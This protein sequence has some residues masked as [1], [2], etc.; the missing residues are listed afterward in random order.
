M[1]PTSTIQEALLTEVLVDLARLL[2]RAEALRVVNIESHDGLIGAHAQLVDQLTAFASQVGELTERAK[3]QTVKHILARTDEATR[4]AIDTQGKAMAKAANQLFDSRVD[5][6]IQQ[7][8]SVIARQ[9]ERLDHP[10][11][12]WLTHAATAVTASASTLAIVAY[13]WPR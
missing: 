7:L 5:P 8:V 10:W 6:R 11:E 13:L 3:V 1:N 9:V 12:L 2:D 4:L